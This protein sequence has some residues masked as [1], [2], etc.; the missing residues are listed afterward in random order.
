MRSW[1]LSMADWNA[2]LGLDDQ[3]SDLSPF[4]SGKNGLDFRVRGGNHVHDTFATR[5]AAAAPASVAASPHPRRLARHRDIA[6]AN[7]LFP[8]E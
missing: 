5:R 4:L 7:V 8:C 3:P 6:G 1:S 2:Q